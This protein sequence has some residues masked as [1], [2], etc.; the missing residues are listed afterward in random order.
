MA[1]T[2]IVSARSEIAAFPMEPVLLSALR[3]GM[4][5]QESSPDINGTVFKIVKILAGAAALTDG[6]AVKFSVDNTVI[7]TPATAVRQVD[8][9]AIYDV[10]LD[11]SNDRAITIAKSGSIVKLKANAAVASGDQLETDAVVGQVRTSA[12]ATNNPRAT[13]TSV[14]VGGFCTAQL[15]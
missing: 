15:R 1:I 4:I 8:G 14:A 2:R 12:A 9:V 13:A 5:G 7:Q 11:A 3:G 6:D 10:A